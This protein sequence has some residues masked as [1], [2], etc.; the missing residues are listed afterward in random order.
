MEIKYKILREGAKL[1]TKGTEGSG[2]YDLTALNKVSTCFMHTSSVSTYGTGL[3]VEIPKDYVG[4]IIERSS[5]HKENFTL[6]NTV[7]VIDSDYRGEVLVKLKGPS[8]ITKEGDRVAQL[9]VIKAEELEFTEVKE[10][11]ST[12]RSGG[13]GSTGRK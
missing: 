13:F 12:D 9:L 2:A 11:S 6:A 1:P 7:G 10:L 3:A 5:L 4:L 8:N